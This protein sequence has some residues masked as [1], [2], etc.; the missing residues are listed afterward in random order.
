LENGQW[1]GFEAAASCN[2]NK[3]K[4]KNKNHLLHI[5]LMAN[6]MMGIRFVANAS[7]LN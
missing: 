4:N 7:P 2:K 3:N 1:R 5:I 6:G